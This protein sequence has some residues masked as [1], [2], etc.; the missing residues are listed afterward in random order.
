MNQAKLDSTK[1]KNQAT[2]PRVQIVLMLRFLTAKRAVW[3][4]KSL[5][6][7]QV[8]RLLEQGTMKLK[9]LG[10]RKSQVLKAKIE[11]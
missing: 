6:A 5:Q 10:K 9:T 8:R 7:R 11:E 4:Q 1:A 3:L 2:S